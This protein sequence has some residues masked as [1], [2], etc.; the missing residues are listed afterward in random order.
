MDIV[1]HCTVL[2]LHRTGNQ[3]VP[4]VLAVTVRVKERDVC[5]SQGAS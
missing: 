4:G 2:C 3:R 5:L 1:V